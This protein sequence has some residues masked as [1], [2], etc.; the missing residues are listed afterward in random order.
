MIKMHDIFSKQGSTFKL[1][2]PR[3]TDI[4]Y[5]ISNGYATFQ[6]LIFITSMK[7]FNTDEDEETILSTSSW[8]SIIDDKDNKH[9]KIHVKYISLDVNDRN[10]NE[11]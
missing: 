5:V 4:V 9:W 1:P 6:S 8:L 10:Q 7:V 3:P 11:K 2:R